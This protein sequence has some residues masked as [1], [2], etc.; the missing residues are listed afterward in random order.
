LL[1]VKNINV[2]YGLA[3]VLWDVSFRVQKGEVVAIVGS[4]GAGKSTTLKAISG[5]IRLRS[6]SIEFN[7]ER[8]DQI[9]AY[10]VV[11]KQI[12]LVPEGRRVFPF[13]SVQAN[14]ELGAFTKRARQKA[15]ESLKYVFGLFPVLQERMNQLAGTLSGGEQQMLAIGRGLMSTPQLLMLDEPSLGLAPI[16]VLKVLDVLQKLNQEGLTLMLIEQNVH[17]ALNL[18][19]RGYVIEN[20]RIVIEGSGQDL[21][22]NAHVKEAYLGIV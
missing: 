7:G 14:L 18:S 1:E 3:Q 22:N 20:G 10:S 16:M 9:P 12:A 17:S 6:G 4:N 15:A 5:L 19:G 8:L 11:E 13:S 21:L 2:A